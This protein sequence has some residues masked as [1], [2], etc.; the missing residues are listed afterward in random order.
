MTHFIQNGS[1]IQV[2]DAADLTVFPHLPAK[3]YVVSFTPDKGFFLK[4]ME[5][6][7]VSGKVYGDSE[8]KC[9]RYFK[10]FDSEPGNL[11]ILLV[12]EKGSGK[13]LLAKMISIKGYELGFPTLVINEPHCGDLFNK[14]MQAIDQPVVCLFDEFEK[15]YGEEDQEKIL[16]LLDG[17][18]NSHKMFVFTANQYRKL[19]RNLNNRPSRIRYPTHFKGMGEDMIEEYVLDKGWDQVTLD[20]VLRISRV[21]SNFNFDMLASL[22]NEC[23]LFD[24]TPIEAVQSLGFKPESLQGGENIFEIFV[25]H[26]GV[27]LSRGAQ[28]PTRTDPSPLNFNEIFVYFDTSSLDISQ[29]MAVRHITLENEDYPPR[30]QGGAENRKSVTL[31]MKSKDLNISKRC[32]EYKVD[33]DT[34]VLFVKQYGAEF[35][36]S[37]F[38]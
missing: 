3:T 32:I 27:T 1:I 23:K 26:K 37:T 20:Q 33:E 11:G 5:S 29:E 15:T 35:D 14:F 6:V 8:E 16:T 22:L 13:T 19:D 34:T 12:G 4:E 30:W 10:A 28:I 24:E 38:E 17:T 7:V 21:F 36:W 18:F 9:E 31:N 2:A 25:V